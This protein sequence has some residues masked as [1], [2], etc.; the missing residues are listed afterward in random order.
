ME[1]KLKTFIKDHNKEFDVYEPSDLWEPISN[2][3]TGESSQPFKSTAN[4]IIKGLFWGVTA[5]SIIAAS[6]YYFITTSTSASSSS[7]HEERNESPT[8]PQIEEGS[9]LPLNVNA[10][11]KRKEEE[12]PFEDV[13]EL[14]VSDAEVIVI[15]DHENITVIENIPPSPFV[16]VAFKDTLSDTGDSLFNGI[17]IVEI[18]GEFF[19]I[20][21]KTHSSNTVLFHKESHITAKGLHSKVPQYKVIADKKDSVLKIAIDCNG[22][23]GIVMIGSLVIE[24]SM[25]LTVPEGTMVRIN[26][27]SGNVR[28]NGLKSPEQSVVT[29]SGDIS[30]KNISSRINLQSVSG[31]IKSE[32]CSGDQKLGT[33][34]GNQSIEK[35]EGNIVTQSV[36]GDLKINGINGNISV[37]SSSG[38]QIIS[39]VRGNIESKA[40]SG[41]IKLNDCKG[42]LSVKTSSG[43]IIGKN[44]DLTGNST[45]ECV[46]GDIRIDFAN[47]NKQLSYELSTISGD[48]SIDNGTIV[49]RDEKRLL[50]NEG[51]I[52]VSGKTSSGNQIFK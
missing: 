36:S 38:N 27:T 52:K 20:Y 33:S 42:Q 39:A 21:V 37:T 15:P 29:G 8:V 3:I 25:D 9:P 51:S 30:V 24:A 49:I 40:V 34:S 2:R 12:K 48:L 50:H 23:R 11:G 16:S 31:D 35:T 13:K 5:S 32:N 17:K 26:N 45:L 4:G 47:D 1:D 14:S 10:P 41:D 6:C 44:I 46:S 43:D 19:D 22:K 28:I 18:E 7:L